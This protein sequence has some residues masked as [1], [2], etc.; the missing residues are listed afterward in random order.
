M[1]ALGSIENEEGEVTL[2]I[3]SVIYDF[4]EKKRAFLSSF[5]HAL[6]IFCSSSPHP[7]GCTT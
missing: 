4:E 7:G 2:D 1:Q 5:S 6:I 3:L